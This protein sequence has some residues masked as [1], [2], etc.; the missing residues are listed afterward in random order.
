MSSNDYFLLLLNIIIITYY[1]HDVFNIIQYNY[2]CVGACGSFYLFKPTLSYATYTAYSLPFMPY[3]IN[4]YRENHVNMSWY[5][6][7]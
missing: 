6:T 5:T 4:Q 3:Y 1:Y 2:V 7:R